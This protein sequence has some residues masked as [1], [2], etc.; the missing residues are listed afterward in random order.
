[1][2]L[3]ASS[4]ISSFFKAEPPTKRIKLLPGPRAEPESLGRNAEVPEPDPA[5]VERLAK[6]FSLP[7]QTVTEQVKATWRDGNLPLNA[8]YEPVRHIE[9][10]Q[11]LEARS[12]KSYLKAFADRAEIL[13][14]DD[15]P[16]GLIVKGPAGCG[17]TS[18]VRAACNDLGLKIIELNASTMRSGTALQRVIGESTQTYS[19]L[20]KQTPT[21]I[22]LDDVD[23]IFDSDR[24][25]F[26]AL[27]ELVSQTK[28]PIVLTCSKRYAAKV[29]DQLCVRSSFKMCIVSVPSMHR[30]RARLETINYWECLGFDGTQLEF[31]ARLCKSD[32]GRVLN[33]MQMGSFQ[34]ILSVK[35]KLSVSALLRLELEYQGRLEVENTGVHSRLQLLQF[36]HE[37]ALELDMDIDQTSAFYSLLAIS[38]LSLTQVSCK[39]YDRR[40]YAQPQHNKAS[41]LAGLS[42]QLEFLQFYWETSL[43][44]EGTVSLMKPTPPIQITSYLR[45]EYGFMGPP[46][47]YIS[48]MQ[49]LVHSNYRQ[50]SLRSGKS[51]GDLEALLKKYNKLLNTV[52]Y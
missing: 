45:K 19:V 41:C 17:K 15:K 31:L 20:H 47:D 10:I 25:F 44:P 14:L 28:S 1:M 43:K 52:S 22:L 18:L 34:S 39:Q 11:H 23:V 32:I 42:A 13:I 3:E 49:S 2:N 6:E 27:L 26:K 29:P 38:D 30:L 51:T 46:T 7:V 4:S 5:F 12:I 16:Q 40:A 9:A 35:G 8:K 37:N 50:I 33:M 24:G 21:A 36:V 48:F